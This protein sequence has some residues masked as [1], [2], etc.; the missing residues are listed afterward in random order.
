MEP[1]YHRGDLVLVRT[2]KNYEVGDIVTYMHPTLGPII[3]RIVGETSEGFI[4]KGDNNTWLDTHPMTEDAIVGKAWVHLRG[5]ANYLEKVRDPSIL[6]IFVFGSLLALM[7]VGVKRNSTD[8]YKWYNSATMT[9]FRSKLGENIEGVLYIAGAFALGFALLAIVAFRNPLTKEVPLEIPYEHSGEF[10]YFSSAPGDVYEDNFIRSGD[11]IFLN[12]I[13]EFDIDFQYDIHSPEASKVSGTHRLDLEIRDL[14][15]WRRTL[16]LDQETPFEESNFTVTGTINIHE[17]QKIVRSLEQKTGLHRSFYEVVIIPT[18][19]IE[20]TLGGYI[21]T[22]RFSP[23]LLFQFDDVQLQLIRN[24]DPLNNSDPLEPHAMEI[25]ERTKTIDE[26]ISILGFEFSVRDARWVS[27]VGLILTLGVLGL[28]AYEISESMQA[29]GTRHIRTKYA[30]L[31]IE[32]EPRKFKSSE[33]V[34]DLSSMDDLARIA[35]NN[36]KMIFHFQTGQTHTYYVTDNGA[37]YRFTTDEQMIEEDAD[38]SSLR[39]K[40]KPGAE[41]EGNDDET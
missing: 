12:L 2:E 4:F 16:V 26:T 33:Q 6:A 22:D 9:D 29:G 3:H 34:V 20:G 14:S 31:I 5:G 40:A 13:Q 41:T 27:V 24:N 25:V 19:Y 10:M 30:S 37:A 8:P 38:D 11:P 1:T 32:V 39:T 35:T 28:A 17:L 36:D 18:I 15:G 7:A 21:F 23:E